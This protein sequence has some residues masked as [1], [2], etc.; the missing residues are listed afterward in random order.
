MSIAE[1]KRV[2]LLDTEDI[3]REVIQ[4]C[5]ETQA[6][7]QVLPAASVQE[8]MAIAETEPIDLVLL[9]L[10]G[11]MSDIEWSAILQRLQNNP[12]TQHI[13]VILLTTT[14]PPKELEGATAGV[15]ASI[16]KPFDLL[17]LAGQVAA[18]LGWNG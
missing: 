16:V 13:P 15:K 6:G 14:A 11:M 10:D 9:D 4:L 5:L 1:A 7:W 12:T 17:V 3:I 18:I 2:L 8:G